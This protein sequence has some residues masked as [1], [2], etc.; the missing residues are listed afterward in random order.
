MKSLIGSRRR[1]L[2]TAKLKAVDSWLTH[3]P[4]GSAD[5][6]WESLHGTV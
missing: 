6:Y 2:R 3:Q 1:R 4:A 5:T